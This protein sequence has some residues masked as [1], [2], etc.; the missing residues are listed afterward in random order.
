LRQKSN[1]L[2]AQTHQIEGV[3]RDENQHNIPLMDSGQHHQQIRHPL[4]DAKASAKVRE[5]QSAGESAGE[6]GSAMGLL[7]GIRQ[8]RCRHEFTIK[9]T[10]EYIEFFGHTSKTPN[11]THTTA[12]CPKCGYLKKWVVSH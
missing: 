11:A 9:E 5:R 1:K 6:R 3:K 4:A 8:A 12:F 2:D 7:N 10:D